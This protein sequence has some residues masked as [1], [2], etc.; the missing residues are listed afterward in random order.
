MIYESL[1]CRGNTYLLDMESKK[2]NNKIVRNINNL[3]INK[4]VGYIDCSDLIE[5]MSKMKIC[6][7]NEFNEVFAEVEKVAFKLNKIL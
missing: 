4:K 2:Q 6:K 1:S 5:G 3:I 7:Q